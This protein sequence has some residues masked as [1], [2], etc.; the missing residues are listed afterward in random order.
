MKIFDKF[1]VAAT[2]KKTPE[3]LI[4]SCHIINVVLLWLM[5]KWYVIL[6]DFLQLDSVHYHDDVVM[7][8]KSDLPNLKILMSG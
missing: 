7:I 1:F 2:K 3:A 6:K 4:F 8:L 5:L